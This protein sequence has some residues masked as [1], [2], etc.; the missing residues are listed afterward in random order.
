MTCIKNT[1]SDIFS[2]KIKSQKMIFQSAHFQVSDRSSFIVQPEQK[3]SAL[4]FWKQTQTFCSTIL[5]S[6]CLFHWYLSCLSFLKF[7]VHMFLAFFIFFYIGIFMMGWAM[8]AMNYMMGE[9]GCVCIRAGGHTVVTYSSSLR[10]PIWCSTL[11]FLNPKCKQ[12][13]DGPVPLGLHWTVW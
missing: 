9:I 2:H 11:D 3:I 8:W 4:I 10:T 5:K 12:A 6:V 1:I 7:G 13:I